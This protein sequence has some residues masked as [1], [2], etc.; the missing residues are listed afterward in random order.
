[1]IWNQRMGEG[2][3]AEA[4]QANA[5]RG[6]KG[7]FACCS[8]SPLPASLF[9]LAR[10]FLGWNPSEGGAVWGCPGRKGV[11]G[12]FHLSSKEPEK[13]PGKGR[14]DAEA[15]DLAGSEA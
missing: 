11:H 12:F 10:W 8:L 9:P 1:M 3:P 14:D 7:V 13:I 4:D 15:E 6:V 5:G 2:F